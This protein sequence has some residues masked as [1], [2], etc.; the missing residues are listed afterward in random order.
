MIAD[1]RLQRRPRSLLHMTAAYTAAAASA[2][3]CT[4]VVLHSS[5]VPTRQ[6]L[7]LLLPLLSLCGKAGQCA[8][9]GNVTTGEAYL[10]TARYPLPSSSYR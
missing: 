7:W 4:P 3:N 8:F 9:D 5:R 2:P 1:M 6:L 10:T